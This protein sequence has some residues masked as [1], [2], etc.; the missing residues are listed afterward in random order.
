MM[1]VT[2]PAHTA[3]SANAP[4]LPAS[5]SRSALASVLSRYF[6]A[7]LYLMLYTAVLTLV[8]TGKLDLFTTI[9]APSVL[10]WKG[11]RRW[12]GRAPEFSSRKATYFIA[13]YFLFAP[14]DY[15]LARNR[16][17][18]AP[19]PALYAALLAT[20]HMLL[21]AMM[22][23]LYSARTRRDSL[24]LA[25]IAFACMLA[26]AVLTVDTAYLAFFLIFLTL[27]VSTFIALEMERGA[28]HAS[29]APIIAGSSQARTLVRALTAV[30]GTVAFGALLLGALLFFMLPRFTAGYLGSYS[31]R[32]QLMTGFTENV[33]LGQIGQIQKSSEVVMRVK[34][35]GDPAR[36]ASQ[37]WRRI[38]LIHFDG[39]RWS[40]L[41]ME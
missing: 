2:K 26:A 15:V 5:E 23:R 13:G 19:N 32:P 21:F 28:E 24:F 20:V 30:S 8:A 1:R 10:V 25:V 9:V 11:F 3:N 41:A 7:S 18:D 6:E 29:S 4:V 37:H 40:S 14:V 12:R 33:E 27:G 31:M 38:A 36:F 34:V 16:A 35:E 39:R 17:T 22:V